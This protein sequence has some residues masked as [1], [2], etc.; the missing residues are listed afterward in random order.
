MSRIWKKKM[1]R[2]NKMAVMGA[3]RKENREMYVKGI[4]KQVF[5]MSKSKMQSA[6][7]GLS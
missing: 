5:G 6:A 2:S 7:W 3:G 1:H 4:A